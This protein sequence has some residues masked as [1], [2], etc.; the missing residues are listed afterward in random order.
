MKRFVKSILLF[1]LPVVVLLGVGEGMV[2]CYPN[3]YRYKHEWMLRHGADVGTL[4][5]GSSQM[6]ADIDPALLPGRAFSLANVSQHYEQDWFLLSQYGLMMKSLTTVVIGLDDCMPFECR[7][8]DAEDSYRATYY[9]L[10]MGHRK[11]ALLSP[12]G[13]ELFHPDQFRRKLEHMFAG[14]S[15]VECDSLGQAS[16]FITLDKF[17]G[18][19]M[20]RLASNTWQRH[21]CRDRR[22][23]VDNMRYVDSIALWCNSHGVRLVLV[24]PPLW[25]GY[26]GMMDGWQRAAIDSLGH[27]KARQHGALYFNHMGDTGLDSL[28]F[29]DPDHLSLQG[30]AKFTRLLASQLPR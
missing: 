12:Y 29:H 2:R 23:V 5:L 10:Y 3:S 15:A 9:R 4:V 1:A 8:E 17:N 24:T 20:N 16:G 18:K 19:T 27:A 25:E 30:A 26:I 28:D 21:R 7:L 13:M 6:Y 11:H 22:A 14:K